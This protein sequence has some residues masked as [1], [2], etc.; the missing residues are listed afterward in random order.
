MV[1]EPSFSYLHSSISIPAAKEAGLVEEHRTRCC[2]EV[3]M[4]PARCIERWV[5][6]SPGRFSAKHVSAEARFVLEQWMQGEFVSKDGGHFGV[7][8]A[9]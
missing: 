7:G 9:S 2:G 1:S 6:P 3:L 5:L 8:F 4:H